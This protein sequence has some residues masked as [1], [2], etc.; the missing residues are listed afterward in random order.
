LEK[1]RAYLEISKFFIRISRDFQND[2]TD[3]ISTVMINKIKENVKQT[4]FVTIIED[5]VDVS[6]RSQLSSVL[7]YATPDFGVQERFIRFSDV[8]EAHSAASLPGHVFNL[9]NDFQCGEKLVAQNLRW[10]SGYAGENNGLQTLI[11]DKYGTALFVHQFNLLLRQSAECISDCK[12]IF[13]TLSGFT[14][15]FF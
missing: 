5:E 7:R 12:I 10:C 1:S 14:A 11:H 2:L 15:F 6:G 4:F 13:E 8:S 3:A 9:I